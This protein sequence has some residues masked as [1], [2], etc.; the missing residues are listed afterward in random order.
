MFGEN[1]REHLKMFIEKKKEIDWNV[2]A[3]ERHRESIINTY[4]LYILIWFVC[5]WNE[6]S[7]WPSKN[8]FIKNKDFVRFVYILLIQSYLSCYS[9][10]KY[11][12]SNMVEK[13][14]EE[15]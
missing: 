11:N 12:A 3:E 14:T 9:F 8:A 1:P 2:G 5:I 10:T 6:R 7:T 4:I 15:E 13:T